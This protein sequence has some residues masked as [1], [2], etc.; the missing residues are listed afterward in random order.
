MARDV[1]TPRLCPAAFLS[2]SVACQLPIDQAHPLPS[3]LGL[4]AR[5]LNALR[6][7]QCCS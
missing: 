3:M 6:V 7:V 4:L 5:S 1:F 2:L